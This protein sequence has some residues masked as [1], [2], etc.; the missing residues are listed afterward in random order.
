MKEAFELI[1]KRIEEIRVLE[2]QYRSKA[3]KENDYMRANATHEGVSMLNHAITIVDSVEAEYGNG[4]IDVRDRLPEKD[5]YCLVTYESGK[6]GI[7]EYL[8][9]SKWGWNGE[10]ADNR[11]I[12]WMPLPSPYKGV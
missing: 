12:A 9:T 5:A 1:R 6:I 2:R 10:F 8:E 11:V 7:M 4:W 3:L